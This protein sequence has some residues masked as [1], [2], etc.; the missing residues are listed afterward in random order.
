M[1]SSV[2]LSPHAHLPHPLRKAIWDRPRVGSV[3]VH[4]PK[5]VLSVQ[6]VVLVELRGAVGGGRD[7][8]RVLLSELGDLQVPLEGGSREQGRSAGRGSCGGV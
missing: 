3:F 2:A 6:L 4:C 8:V 7:G 5:Q 1:T